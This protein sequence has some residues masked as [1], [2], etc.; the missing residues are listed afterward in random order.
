MKHIFVVVDEK[1]VRKIVEI[2]MKKLGYSTSF[3]NDGIEAIE[4]LQKDDFSADLIILDVMLPGL[5]GFEISKQIRENPKIKD[6]PII[7][8]TAL[9]QEKNVQQ[10]L[11]AGV[12]E[13]IIKPFSVL[14]LQDKVKSILE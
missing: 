10:G 8:I 12:N 9:A 3:A 7:M 4:I 5:N 13:Y 1:N 11:D 14:E 2:S 6:I